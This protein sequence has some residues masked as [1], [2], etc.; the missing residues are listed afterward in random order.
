MKRAL[1]LLPTLLM[2]ASSAA[3][4][5][6]TRLE[7]FRNRLFL[8]AT[9]N[10][11]RVVAL[12][13]SAAEMTIVDA[14]FAA[15]LRLRMGAAQLVNGS[16]GEDKGRFAHG[17]RIAAAGVTVPATTAVVLD[18]RDLSDRLIGRPVSVILGRELFDAARLHIDLA[19]RS[20][21]AVP[22]RRAPP[23]RRYPLTSQRGVEVFPVAVEGHAPA[24]AEFDLGNGSEVL[25]GKGYAERIGLLAPERIVGR[26]EG[27]GIG[28]GRSRAIVVLRTLEVGGRRFEN[29]RAAIDD[30][31]SAADV[32]VGTSIL[33]HFLITVDYA[34]HGLWLAPR[35]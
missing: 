32:N 3:A 19:R 15:G 7:L 35:P 11:I 29:V 5:P 2:L 6:P 1:L 8:P 17:L 26:S 21:A 23:G 16:G 4:A 10:G 27:G 28:G 30:T 24:Q 12:L 31:A 9:V 22:R 33:R 20:L 13:D 25:I 18:L 14:P 34:Q